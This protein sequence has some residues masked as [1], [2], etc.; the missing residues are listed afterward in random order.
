M[1]TSAQNSSNF[2]FGWA[3]GKAAIHIA[4]SN[5]PCLA[6]FVTLMFALVKA[7]TTVCYYYTKSVF[8]TCYPSLITANLSLSLKKP[9]FAVLLATKGPLY[10]HFLNGFGYKD[11]FFM[12]THPWLALFQLNV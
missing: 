1:T 6:V 11:T 8:R 3:P 7:R 9:T 4:N 5:H 12:S 10:F 2:P